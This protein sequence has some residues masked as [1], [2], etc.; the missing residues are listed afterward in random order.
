MTLWSRIIGLVYN[1]QEQEIMNELHNTIISYV[2]ECFARFVMG[3][4]SLDRDWDNYLAEFNKMRLADV[5]RA[6]QSCWDRMNR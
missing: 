3:D 5:I 2:Q 4:L 6:T 1:E